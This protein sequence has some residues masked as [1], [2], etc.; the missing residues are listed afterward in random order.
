M[1][2]G[3]TC[4]TTYTKSQEQNGS[5]VDQKKKK[6]EDQGGIEGCKGLDSLPSLMQLGVHTF[7]RRTERLMD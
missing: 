2:G 7:I 4:R 6:K 3:S 1:V 5:Q